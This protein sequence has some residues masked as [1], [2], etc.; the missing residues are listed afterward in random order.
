[1]CDVIAQQR[2]ADYDPWVIAAFREGR[3][4]DDI[5]VI[6]CDG[7]GTWSYYNQ[8]SHAECRTCERDLTDLIDDA[9]TMEDYW[10]SAVYPCDE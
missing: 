7:C 5:W 6:R 2:R 10:S 4:V 1:M 3:W 8:G 9:I